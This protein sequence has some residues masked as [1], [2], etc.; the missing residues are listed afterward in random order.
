MAEFV[1]ERQYERKARLIDT[2]TRQSAKYAALEKLDPLELDVLLG[3]VCLMH[4]RA[5][6]YWR[7]LRRRL[8]ADL[9]QLQAPPHAKKAKFAELEEMV[10]T[11]R[12]STT[13][14]VG[15]LRAWCADD[16]D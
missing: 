5:E 15:R 10:T 9:N 7:F 4:T 16:D 1:K 11:S 12:L 13:M 3:E 8:G 2:Y 14:Q 6:L